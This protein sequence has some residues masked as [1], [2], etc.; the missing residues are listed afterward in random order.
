MKLTYTSEWEKKWHSE[1]AELEIALPQA[2]AYLR[3]LL[4]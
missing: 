3:A 2:V 1:I 4:E